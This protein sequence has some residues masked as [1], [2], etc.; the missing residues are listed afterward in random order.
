[1]AEFYPI[2][3]APS[4]AAGR[5]WKDGGQE[6]PAY[7]D[8]D[9]VY[10]DVENCRLEWRTNDPTNAM[11]LKDKGSGKWGVAG[12]GNSSFLAMPTYVH[13]PGE[14]F[15]YLACEYVS[16]KLIAFGPRP[17][18]GGLANVKFDSGLTLTNDENNVS[19]TAS[20]LAIGRQYCRIRRNSAM[21]VF[22]KSGSG[23]EVAAVVMD[24]S[25]TFAT[26][27]ARVW[28]LFEEYSDPD[29]TV[30]GAILCKGSVTVDEDAGFMDTMASLI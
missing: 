21:Q 8:L 20:S 22:F 29:N 15:I 30:F 27:G 28:P 12:N 2:L 4:R 13:C 18:D 3:I 19:F 6:A 23:P 9:P 14:F 1:M 7:N 10:E 25:F 17:A 11:I 24:G 26:L 5:L 16:G